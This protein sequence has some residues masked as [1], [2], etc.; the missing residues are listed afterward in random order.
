MLHAQARK[1]D[2][3][4][5]VSRAVGELVGPAAKV[6]DPD[7]EHKVR[8]E[9]RSL[10]ASAHETGHL[11]QALAKHR[12]SP[13]K[14]AVKVQ[15]D[16]KGDSPGDLEGMRLQMREM[17]ATAC[18]SGDLQNVLAKARSKSDPAEEV[19]ELESMRLQMRSML[20]N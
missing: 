7:E 18:D 11:E 20:E 12:L 15:F 6:K 1:Q 5:H 17:L 16:Q 3:H 19:S 8:L 9:V 14:G 13:D 10:M 4:D 2:H